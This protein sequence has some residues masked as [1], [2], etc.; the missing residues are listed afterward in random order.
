MKDKKMTKF[1][2]KRN[3]KLYSKAEVDAAET[4]VGMLVTR[5]MT[6]G[7][8]VDATLCRKLHAVVKGSLHLVEEPM[9]GKIAD[10]LGLSERSVNV[11]CNTC[12]AVYADVGTK[13]GSTCRD[14]GTTLQRAEPELH[15]PLLWLTSGG[16]MQ[17]K[18]KEAAI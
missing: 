17:K 8:V 9:K 15:L 16:F 14:C 11:F 7:S 4:F 1:M 10:Y 3:R 2:A 18:K 12:H 5:F 13:M 6:P